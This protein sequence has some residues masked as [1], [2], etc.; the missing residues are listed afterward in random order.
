MRLKVY[1]ESLQHAIP[2]CLFRVVSKGW[3]FKKCHFFEYFFCKGLAI[4][5]TKILCQ[6]NY[7]LFV[8]VFS[9]SFHTYGQIGSVRHEGYTLLWGHC[10]DN[11]WTDYV[12]T[13]IVVFKLSW[14]WL[15]DSISN[16]KLQIIKPVSAEPAALGMLITWRLTNAETQRIFVAYDLNKG[17]SMIFQAHVSPAWPFKRE[18]FLKDDTRRDHDN[19]KDARVHSRLIPPPLASHT[20]L[21]W[22]LPVACSSYL[23]NLTIL[24]H[25]T[26][27]R[28]IVILCVTQLQER[29]HPAPAG[30]SLFKGLPVNG[31]PF[32]DYWQW[33][34][35]LNMEHGILLNV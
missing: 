17:C 19:L 2:A 25:C 28:R 3:S 6:E 18:S 7:F 32:N 33:C 15:F 29:R 11:A 4:F 14:L 30:L 26:G 34:W 10:I 21:F 20:L 22:S 13:Q 35:I 5:L 23:Q 31:V 1:T 16:C 27:F 24:H 12:R 8:R 9:G